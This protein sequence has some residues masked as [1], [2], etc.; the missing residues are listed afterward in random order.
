MTRNKKPSLCGGGLGGGYLFRHCEAVA[1]ATKK[2]IH[3]P[4]IA[5][6]SARILVAIYV[7]YF[8]IL[9]DCHAN[10]N[11]FA[12]NDGVVN[13]YENSLRS[14]AGFASKSRSDKGGHIESSLRANEV[15]V[16]IQNQTR[17]TQKM[18]CYDLTSSSLAMTI[19]I[20]IATRIHFVHSLAMAKLRLIMTALWITKETS[21]RLFSKETA[22]RL[23]CHASLATCSQ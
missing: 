10:A 2:A 19:G 8:F 1:L 12:R 17:L 18:D 4:V 6:K 14:F 16:A 7:F 13:C 3:K 23:F 20:W 11:A 22:L 15:S 9:V 21:L 5:R